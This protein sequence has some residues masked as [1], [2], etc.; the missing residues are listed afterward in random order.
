MTLSFLHRTLHTHRIV[1]E[2]RSEKTA[3][4]SQEVPTG[5]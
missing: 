1:K 5:G 2:Q 3:S 4:V